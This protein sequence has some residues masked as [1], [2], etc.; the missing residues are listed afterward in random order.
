MS[1]SRLRQQWSISVYTGSSL[2]TLAPERAG[3]RPAL[4]ARDVSDLP[5]RAVADPFLLRHDGAWWLFFEVW[6]AET[7]RGEIACATSPDAGVSWVYQSSVLREP[8]HLSYPHVFAWE[9]AIYMVPES[10]QDRAVH[11][12][13]ADRLPRGWRR[14]ST[15][16]R[17]AYADATLLRFEDRWWMFAQRG[18][19][20]LCLFSSDRLE[21]GWTPHPASPLWTGNRSRTRPGGRMLIEDGRLIRVAQ[22]AWPWYGHSLRAFHVRQLSPARY[23]EEEV[24]GSPILRASRAGWNAV[25]MHHLDAVRRDDGRW[26]A[27]VDGAALAQF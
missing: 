4:T 6:N 22:D 2:S 27:V 14:V 23:D 1:S 17:G 9:G 21:T 24:P 12:Y 15:L 11:L 7:G 18:L 16:L 25:G 5:G 20:E 13:V 8:F 3:G 26:L 10:R 19:D